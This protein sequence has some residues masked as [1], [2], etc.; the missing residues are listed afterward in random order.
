[1]I[2]LVGRLNH[3]LDVADQPLGATTS[4]HVGAAVNPFAADPDEEWRR[5]ALKVEAG[6]EFVVT[7]PVLDIEGFERALPRLRATGLPVLAGVAALE[8]LRHAEFLSS[9]VIGV[10]ASEALLDR[11]K[12]ATDELAEARTV[13]AEIVTWLRSRVDGLVI[14]TLHGAGTSAEAVW[15]VLG[16]DGAG[17]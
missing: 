2:N 17:R 3:G 12:Q 8:G 11:L 4:F 9:E 14:T 7:P 6:A 16:S 13:T 1:L 15:R 5:L 10:R